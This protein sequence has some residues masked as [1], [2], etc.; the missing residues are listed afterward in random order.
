MSVGQERDQI[1]DLEIAA[2]E[3]GKLLAMRNR[4]LTDNG[5]GQS[6]VYWGFVMPFLGNIEMPN[7]YTWEKATLA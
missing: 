1:N 7:A 4:C 3:D 6:G 2:S 5:T